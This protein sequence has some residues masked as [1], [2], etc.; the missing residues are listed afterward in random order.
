MKRRR[1]TKSDKIKVIEM[2]KNGIPDIEI[3]AR[4]GFGRGWVGEVST[5]YW[6]DK[7]KQNKN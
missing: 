2:A 7:M 6:K 1:Y 3:A 4:L 5:L